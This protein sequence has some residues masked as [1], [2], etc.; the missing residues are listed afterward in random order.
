MKRTDAGPTPLIGN[1]QSVQAPHTPKS[2]I[3]KSTRVRV[4]D[5]NFK[6]R[7]K[8]AEDCDSQQRTKVT[9]QGGELDTILLT[10]M[11]NSSFC[12]GKHMGLLS[13]LLHQI[14]C[15]FIQI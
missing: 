4:R 9:S 15:S 1:N 13:K 6:E 2:E 12:L 5:R 11:Q 3:S 14:G 8:M 10:L 7:L